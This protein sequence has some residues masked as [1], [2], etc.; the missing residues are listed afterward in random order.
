MRASVLISWR[1]S[2]QLD[3]LGSPSLLLDRN[4]AMQIKLGLEL[5]E[6]FLL[7]LSIYWPKRFPKIRQKLPDTFSVLDWFVV[8]GSNLN[9]LFVHKRTPKESSCLGAT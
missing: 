6:N 2:F 4:N 8:E 3:S 9:P 1:W 5:A 7:R